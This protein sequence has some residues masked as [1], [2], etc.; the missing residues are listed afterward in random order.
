M[1]TYVQVCHVGW[2]SPTTR[3]GGGRSPPSFRDSSSPFRGGAEDFADLVL[4]L[5]AE[6]GTQGQ[7]LALDR[8]THRQRADEADHF[9]VRF[10]QIQQP[11]G[12]L[13]DCGVALVRRA[14]TDGA[15]GVAEE[16]QLSAGQFGE[17]IVV[18][19]LACGSVDGSIARKQPE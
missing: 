15:Q 3:S 14:G 19:F 11:A 10:Q 18:M 12:G 4:D 7:D 5:A 17:G 13:G 8:V 9:A 6:D 16:R 1:Y 2:A